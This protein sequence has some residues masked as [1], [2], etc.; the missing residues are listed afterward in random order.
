M[1]N[2]LRRANDNDPLPRGDR[3]A[4]LDVPATSA[5]LRGVGRLRERDVRICREN[6]SKI[7]LS[8]GSSIRL[9]VGQIA[10]RTVRVDPPTGDRVPITAELCRVLAK[11]IASL[12]LRREV[13][14]EG[15]SWF[16]QLVLC[17]S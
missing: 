17:P 1:E 9:P 2:V 4:K 7:A 5:S 12:K 14:P 8:G 11:F 15:I 16:A 10:M 3:D 6:I 13:D